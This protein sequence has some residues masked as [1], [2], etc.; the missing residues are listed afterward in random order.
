MKR[1][2]LPHQPCPTAQLLYDVFYIREPSAS[3]TCPLFYKSGSKNEHQL[4]IRINFEF[5][6]PEMIRKR[7]DNAFVR[8]WQERIRSISSAACK[9]WWPEP[10]VRAAECA[11]P[12]PARVLRRPTGVPARTARGRA[13]PA[14]RAR[15]TEQAPVGLPPP[16]AR[17]AQRLRLRRAAPVSSCASS[18]WIVRN[19]L[20]ETSF[21]PHVHAAHGTPPAAWLPLAH[22]QNVPPA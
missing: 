18:S 17:R 12:T 22:G 2:S 9:K 11:P 10:L 15:V 19:V 3:S 4:R 16:S 13:G 21:T 7:I 1:P 20:W 5:A 14:P 6:T 8:N